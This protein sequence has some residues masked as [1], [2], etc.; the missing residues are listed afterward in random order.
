MVNSIYCVKYEILIDEQDH[1]YNHSIHSDTFLAKWQQNSMMLTQEKSVLSYELFLISPL[2][3][4]LLVENCLNEKM[5]FC[6]AHNCS[7]WQIL[8]HLSEF[9]KK[10]RHDISWESSAS[11][12]FSW[13]IMPYLLFLKMQQNLKLT[14]AANYRW[15]FMSSTDG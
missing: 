3:H 14:S 10:I 12:R 7:R 4:M 11:R 5:L 15:R 1:L 2:K 6:L 9:S 13:N 8:Q